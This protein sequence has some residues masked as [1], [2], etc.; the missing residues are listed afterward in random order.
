MEK[1]FKNSYYFI[2][3]DSTFSFGNDNKQDELNFK[4]TLEAVVVEARRQI[5]F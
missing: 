5:D 2:A 3:Q 1:H 4:D